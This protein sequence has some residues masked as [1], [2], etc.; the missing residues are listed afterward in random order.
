MRRTQPRQDAFVGHE[1][2]CADATRK[3]D[4]VWV[5]DVFEF[6]IHGDTEE[7]IL[8]AHLAR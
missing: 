4:D 5:A 6:G 8:A 7:A 1:I 2:A 3:H